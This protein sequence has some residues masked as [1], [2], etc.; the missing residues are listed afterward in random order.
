MFARRYFAKRYYAK[1]YWPSR[2]SLIG[3]G[4]FPNDYFTVT[5]FAGVYWPPTGAAPDIVIILPGLH[6]VI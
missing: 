4:F 1:R 5:Y 2:E 3:S 6:T